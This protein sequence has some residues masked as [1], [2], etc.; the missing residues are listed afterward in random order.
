MLKLTFKLG[1]YLS[2]I[3][4]LIFLNSCSSKDSV[5]NTELNQLLNSSKSNDINAR[6]KKIF[7]ELYGW[8]KAKKQGME[9]C[10]M[11]NKGI[12]KDEIRSHNIA[13]GLELISQGKLTPEESADIDIINI[14]IEL[15]AQ[16]SY[17]PDHR[18]VGQ[19]PLKDRLK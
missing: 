5:F 2:F 9:Y 18:D 4:I 13:T 14:S 16:K 15:A 17:C 8:E 1:K 12:S 19:I 6:Q 3:L 11:L 10:Q 7:D